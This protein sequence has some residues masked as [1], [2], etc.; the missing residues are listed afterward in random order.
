MRYS[1]YYCPY[2]QR[3]VS[4]ESEDGE[5]IRTEEGG[6]IYVH[7]DVVHDDDYDFGVLQ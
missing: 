2:C 5:L 4:P 1:G 6:L 7:D 3:E